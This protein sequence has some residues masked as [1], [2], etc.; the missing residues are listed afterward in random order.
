[1][2]DESKCL[3]AKHAFVKLL[4]AD[5]KY[6][7]MVFDTVTVL[8]WPTAIGGENATIS[9]LKISPNPAI[10]TIHITHALG[11]ELS[12]YDAVG[13]LIL[14]TQ[15]KNNTA[16]VDLSFLPQGIYVVRSDRQVARFVKR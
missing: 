16:D 13:K 14:S 8:A 1:M 11:K 3:I 7:A 15:I 12:I 5:A 2:R 9:N 6:N 10:N 4:G